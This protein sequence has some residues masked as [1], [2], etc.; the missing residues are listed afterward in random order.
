MINHHCCWQGGEEIPQLRQI[1]G[2][3]I[4]HHVP[5]Q[6]RNACGDLHKFIF[7]C[8]IDQPFDKVKT[9]TTHT[10]RMHVLQL[11]VRDRA[12][13][14][15]HAPRLTIGGL[16]RIDQCRIV[17]PMASGL[18]NHIL[19]KTKGIAQRKQLRF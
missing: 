10:R 1:N 18:N 14:R 11:C 3:K 12:F 5:A 15:G 9:H 6:R 17:R 4:N 13:N 19:I 2:F 8:E 16:E 7:G